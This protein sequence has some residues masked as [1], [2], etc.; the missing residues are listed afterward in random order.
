M[1]IV[2]E[3]LRMKACWHCFLSDKKMKDPTIFTICYK[4]SV[5]YALPCFPSDKT[6]S[7]LE[8]GNFIGSNTRVLCSP[9]VAEK[10]SN[11]VKQHG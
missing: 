3:L 4:F 9:V 2:E 1:I 8:S 6:S 10:L 11:L 5:I 7:H